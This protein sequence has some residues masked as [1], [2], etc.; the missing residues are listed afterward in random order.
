MTEK[1]KKP[2]ED[3]VT[4]EQLENVAGGMFPVSMVEGGGTA[5]PGPLDVCKTPIIGVP[6]PTPY[7]NIGEMDGTDTATKGDTTKG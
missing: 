6:L 7:P 2:E 5:M 4:A 1:K 3:E